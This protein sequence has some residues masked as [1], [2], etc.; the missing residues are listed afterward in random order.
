[1]VTAQTLARMHVFNLIAFIHY[2]MYIIKSNYLLLQ[3]LHR[4]EVIDRGCSQT[5]PTLNIW[6]VTGEVTS[7]NKKEE[8]FKKWMEQERKKFRVEIVVKTLCVVKCEKVV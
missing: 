6:H 4:A 3:I 1:M 5:R 2:S 7:S 8:T